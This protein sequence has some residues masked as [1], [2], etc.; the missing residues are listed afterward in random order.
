MGLI[1]AIALALYGCGEEM[2][3]RESNR[4][5]VDPDEG[6][7]RTPDSQSLDASVS[8]NLDASNRME[9]SSEV[10]QGSDPDRGAHLDID[11]GVLDLGS[12]DASV[13]GDGLYIPDD[14]PSHENGR[15]V[16]VGS[17]GEILDAIADASPGDVI[18]IREG[19]YDFS[20]LIRVQNDG[21]ADGRI[22]F[23]SD[24]R[25][26]VTLNLSHIEN[27]K[28]YA[29]FWIFENI[30]FVGNCDDGR[31]CEHA[32]HIVGDADDLIFRHNEI[33]NF[34]S[35]VKLNG[36]VVGDG[37]AKS[38]PDRTMFIDNFWHNTRYILNNTP[39]NIL[40][41]D[42]GRDHVVRGNIFADFNTPES[43][44]KSASAVYP[45]ASTLG[46]LIEQNLIVCEK[47]RSAGETTR[48][49]Q[50]GDGAPA[51]ICDGDADQDGLGDCVENAQNQEAIVRNNI[52]MNC[53]N[54][55]SAAGIM[56]GS[57]RASIISHNTVYNV[58]R[59]NAGFYIGHPD[60]DTFWRS[61]IMENGFNTNY[62]ERALNEVDNMM[63][64]L[65]Q[66][67]SIF[68]SPIEGDFSLVHVMGITE[69]GATNDEVPHDFCGYPRGDMADRGAIEYSTTE[70][71]TACATHV[72]EMYNRIP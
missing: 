40:N 26:A 51:S 61:N 11:M 31:G 3:E 47:E 21:R 69:Q 68:E 27:F 1:C 49:I 4:V 46:I 57:D 41:L 58:G 37:P 5:A 60:H 2:G 34:A 55:G 62:A 19:T 72:Q 64:S 56:V 22:F 18:T 7:G 33:I 45:K 44:P 12:T 54:G 36:E 66:M 42:G 43:L 59:R 39:H 30:R 35:H 28:I 63:P 48:G 20:Q 65:D 8:S 38:F 52:I 16:T 71:G 14:G 29:K 53:N 32:F 17:A 23:R 50:L 67:N 70:M 9:M 24:L 10:D 25:D 15:I 6:V 13:I